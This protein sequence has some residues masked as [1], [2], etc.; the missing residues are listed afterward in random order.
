MDT[1]TQGGIFPCHLSILSDNISINMTVNP[2]T[3]HMKPQNTNA[4][5]DSIVV[6]S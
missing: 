2:F 4:N 5:A 6:V 3:T 1:G